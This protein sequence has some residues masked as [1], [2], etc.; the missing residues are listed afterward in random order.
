MLVRPSIAFFAQERRTSTET[1]IPTYAIDEDFGFATVEAMIKTKKTFLSFTTPA[2]TA[3]VVLQVAD[4]V[5][6]QKIGF[7]EQQFGPVRAAFDA[8]TRQVTAY[9]PVSSLNLM[10]RELIWF[11]EEGDTSFTRPAANEILVTLTVADSLNLDRTY[12]APS[13]NSKTA[14]FLSNKLIALGQFSKNAAPTRRR[15][16]ID[17]CDRFDTKILHTEHLLTT[18]SFMIGREKMQRLSDRICDPEGH[19]LL[20]AL[21]C[22]TIGVKSTSIVRYF[23]KDPGGLADK[24][25][26]SPGQEREDEDADGDT[27]TGCPGFIDVDSTSGLLRVGPSDDSFWGL[28]NEEGNPEGAYDPGTARKG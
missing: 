9:G 8:Q 2:L 10:L 4:P 21:Q 25:P 19:K 7:A 15:L 11:W 17:V 24:A 3:T 18:R 26:W 16:A 28:P 23:T 12:N 13:S 5:L 20:Y 14:E 6:R 1:T 22:K 27:W